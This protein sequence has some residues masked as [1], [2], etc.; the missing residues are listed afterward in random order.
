MNVSLRPN[1]G[2]LICVFSIG[3][4]FNNP[5][6]IRLKVNAS[7]EFFGPWAVEKVKTVVLRYLF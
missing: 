4:F 3:G 1:A 7:Y 2:S 5:N 6:F